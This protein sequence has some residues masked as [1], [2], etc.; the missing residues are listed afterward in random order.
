MM[1][2]ENVLVRQIGIV[3]NGYEYRADELCGYIGQ[4]VNIR[5]DP[6]DVSTLYVF[7]LRVRRS[8]RRPVR[9]Y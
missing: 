8:V 3:R 7:D 9:S 2:E 1:K 4:K 5:Y 6:E